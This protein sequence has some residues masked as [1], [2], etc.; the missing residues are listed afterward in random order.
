MESATLKDI[1]DDMERRGFR[2]ADPINLA[3]MPWPDEFTLP[4]DLVLPHGNSV[5]FFL[6]VPQLLPPLSTLV[7]DGNVKRLQVRLRDMT[8]PDES[9]FGVDKTLN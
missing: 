4:A 5:V 9:S 7:C 8:Y 6:D 3:S 2:P 1:K